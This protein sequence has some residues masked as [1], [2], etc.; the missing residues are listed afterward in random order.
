M[1]TPLVTDDDPYL[2]ILNFP[3]EK[4]ILNSAQVCTLLK[5]TPGQFRGWLSRNLIPKADGQL[6]Q[7][8]PYWKLTT[9]LEYV[10]LA[11]GGRLGYPVG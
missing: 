5:L 7:R 2:T 10:R 4:Q 8:T 9:I 1:V 11:P 3:I 6:D